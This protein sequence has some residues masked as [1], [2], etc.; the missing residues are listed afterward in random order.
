[1]SYGRCGPACDV[2]VIPTVV[3]GE[4]VIQC[5]SCAISAVSPYWRESAR[6]IAHLNEH[7]SRGHQVPLYVFHSVGTRGAAYLGEREEVT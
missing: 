2:Y 3:R 6:V 4:K 7:I 5:L 1:M